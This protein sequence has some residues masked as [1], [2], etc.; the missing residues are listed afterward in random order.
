MSGV[1]P[2]VPVYAFLARTGTAIPF[3]IY[4]CILVLVVVMTLLEFRCVEFVCLM[5]ETIYTEITKKYF[6][7]SSTICS[8]I[9][10][11]LNQKRSLS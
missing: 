5:V 11:N 4:H 2:P 8:R 9:L 3:S 1:I 7:F 6:Y 10:T